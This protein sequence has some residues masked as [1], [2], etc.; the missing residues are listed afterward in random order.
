MT[1]S[2]SDKRGYV[3]PQ[4]ELYKEKKAFIQNSM[5]IVVAFATTFFPR[6]I[7]S[8][9]IP[10]IINFAHFPIVF[11]ACTIVII[12]TKVKD[13]N[14]VSIAK[15]LIVGI[16]ILLVVMIAST[17]INKAGLINLFL[18]FM[19]LVEPFLLLIAI[20]CVPISITIIR[21]LKVWL[22]GFA[23]INLFLAFAQ[24]ILITIGILR[25]TQMTAWDNVQ[26][27]FYLSGAGHVVSASVSMSFAIYYFISAKTAPIWLRISIVLA[28]F[29]QLVLAEARQVIVVLMIAWFILILV[30]INDIKTTLQYLIGAALIVYALFWCMQNLEAFA[31]FNTWI[32]PGYYGPDGEATLLKTGAFR[33]IPSYYES[34]LNWLFGLGP[35]HTVGRLGGWILKDYY[36]LL[37]P[38][39]ATIHP[40]S[41][42]VWVTW[43]WSLLD[44]SFFSPL[45]GWAGIWGDLGFLGLGAFLY[46]CSIVWRRVCLDDFSKFMMLTILIFG[47][48]FTQMEE[49]GYML[50]VASLIGLRWHDIQIEKRERSRL[51]HLPPES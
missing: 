9:G 11:L 46:L 29:I 14:Q 17:I 3:N 37:A 16:F 4:I 2:L 42:A 51:A 13:R 45:F 28:A 20:I 24:H 35:G 30:K 41:E 7:S 40:A 19:M 38:L 26:G 33:I 22:L 5:L 8:I 1:K 12:K 48:I 18:A 50:S 34:Q 15:S 32:R 6:I 39:G 47:L 21:R 31:T 44:S 43:R 27:V 23:C 49:P 25:V 36:A 10:K